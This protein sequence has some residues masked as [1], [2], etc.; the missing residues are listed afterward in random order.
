[1]RRLWNSYEIYKQLCR[2]RRQNASAIVLDT[3]E[4]TVL[5]THYKFFTYWK[6]H[7]LDMQ[8]T[9]SIE[10][11]VYKMKGA[12]SIQYNFIYIEHESIRT[13][14]VDLFSALIQIPLFF[15][16]ENVPVNL[17][18]RHYFVFFLIVI[19]A[20]KKKTPPRQ[21]RWWTKNDIHSYTRIYVHTAHAHIYRKWF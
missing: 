10:L 3:D 5:A 9:T 4:F 15:L 7:P 13:F 16:F 21:Q 6:W 18:E 11:Y 19:Y 2:H 8:K 1:M 14:F 17:C 12:A 20:K